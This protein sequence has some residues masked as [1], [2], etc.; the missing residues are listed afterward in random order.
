MSRKLLVAKALLGILLV[1]PLAGTAIGRGTAAGVWNWEEYLRVRFADVEPPAIQENIPAGTIVEPEGEF[2]ALNHNPSWLPDE[3]HCIDHPDNYR[4]CVT[5]II[6]TY[7]QDEQL[8]LRQENGC[9]WWDGKTREWSQRR[10]HDLF[11]YHISGPV[12]HNSCA[13]RMDLE[14]NYDQWGPHGA[15]IGLRSSQGTIAQVWADAGI[16]NGL[17]FDIQGE[18]VLHYP[19]GT[20]YTR[21]TLIYDGDDYTWI[22]NGI[23]RASRA[24]WMDPAGAALYVGNATCQEGIDSWVTFH[25][26]G[27]TFYRLRPY[28]CITGIEPASP[29]PEGTNIVVSA[30]AQDGCGLRSI[31]FYINSAGDGSPDGHWWE[32]GSVDCGG[33][34]KPCNGSALLDWSRAPGWMSRCGTHLIVVNSQKVDGSWSA[35]WGGDPCRQRLFT[36]LCSTPTPT[37]TN[38]STPTPTTPTPTPT[39]TPTATPSAPTPTPTNTP[40]PTPTPTPPPWPLGPCPTPEVEREPY[41]RGMV[42]VENKLWVEMPPGTTRCSEPVNQDGR[43]GWVRCVRW[44]LLPGEPIWDFDDGTVGGGSPVFHTYYT[45]SW[46]KPENGPGLG[47]RNNLPAYQVEVYTRW[48]AFGRETWWEWDG[49]SWQFHDSGWMW[50]DLRAFGWPSWYCE[51]T[52]IEPVPVI[53]VQ[54]IL[55]SP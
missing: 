23:D 50:L 51:S 37:P 12:V 27:F 32:F 45:S 43:R 36:W 55:S 17:V 9:E 31:H 49:N 13:F 5:D 39:S 48:Q 16:R 1:L 21:A 41:P 42:T 6:C 33:T 52:A 35:T 10:G 3:C 26:P 38:T 4:D 14:I 7:I 20:G 8:W 2:W 15:G 40:T 47:G 11:P 54:G 44:E 53:E 29:Q 25:T 46:G 28:L 30:Q 22:V 19:V 24:A 34:M 18:E